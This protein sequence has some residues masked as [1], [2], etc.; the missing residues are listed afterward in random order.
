MTSESMATQL[1]QRI[2]LWRCTRQEMPDGDLEDKWSPLNRVWAKVRMT[3]LYDAENPYSAQLEIVMR[4]TP[5]SFNG[6]E[7][8]NKHYKIISAI[9]ADS[10]KPLWRFLVQGMRQKMG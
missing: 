5:Y 6:I 8:K 1:N 10:E 4:P 7:W 3:K 2:T 9:V